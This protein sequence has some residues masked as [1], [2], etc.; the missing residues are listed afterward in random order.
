MVVPQV[1]S[2]EMD[3]EALEVEEV[4]EV[5]VVLAFVDEVVL[6]DVQFPEAG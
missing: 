5:V 3:W 1:P 2:V 6:V 4:F